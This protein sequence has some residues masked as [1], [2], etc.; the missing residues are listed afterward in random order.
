MSRTRIPTWKKRRWHRDLV[1]R[2]WTYA[3]RPGRPP[4]AAG[5]QQLIL[6]LA[7]ENPSW[8]YKRIQGELVALGVPVSCAH[9]ARG[10][11]D[12]VAAV[13]TTLVS[14]IDQQLPEEPWPDDP[15]R[16]GSD[17]PAEHEESDRLLVRI[18][19]PVPGLALR[20]VAGVSERPGHH[21]DEALLARFYPQSQNRLPI[22]VRD[23]A[24]RDGAHAGRL[25][26]PPERRE[27]APCG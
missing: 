15:R 23:L 6:R 9:D 4:L 17:V 19:R 2:R 26:G 12:R 7:A 14:L 10:K 22:L 11:P 18:D 13:A 20:D 16:L 25:R 8:G 3:G 24:E 5:T 27:S 1:R 21:T